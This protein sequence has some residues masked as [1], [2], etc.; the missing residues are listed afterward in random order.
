V[1]VLVRSCQVSGLLDDRD[2]RRV[3]GVREEDGEDPL[4]VGLVHR[5]DSCHHIVLI[6]AEEIL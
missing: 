2:D 6:Q 4:I 3:Q 1:K 5:L